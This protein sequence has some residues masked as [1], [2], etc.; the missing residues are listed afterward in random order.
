[1]MNDFIRVNFKKRNTA[2]LMLLALMTA[3]LLVRCAPL[4]EQIVPSAVGTLTPTP[5][6]TEI[7]L[8]PTAMP[9]ELARSNELTNNIVLMGVLL[10]TIIIA[11]TFYGIRRRRE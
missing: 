1:M 6:P 4:S 3:L 7:P 10:V 9:S 5:L 2:L 11:G 8:M